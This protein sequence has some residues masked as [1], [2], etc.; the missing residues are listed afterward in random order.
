[1]Q[2]QKIIEVDLNRLTTSQLRLLH[3]L[4][5]KV[6]NNEMLPVT[7]IL[8]FG[9]FAVTSNYSIIYTYL[10]SFLRRN[11]FILEVMNAETVRCY[12]SNKIHGRYIHCKVKL[13]NFIKQ[14]LDECSDF[15]ESSHSINWE[16]AKTIIRAR[17]YKNK[18]LEHHTVTGNSKPY[19]KLIQILNDK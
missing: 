14:V 4:N 7:L 18:I 1:M 19:K 11:I 9:T 12:D 3:A 5:K 6:N 10:H 15:L 13:S 8:R 17:T 2:K 16:V